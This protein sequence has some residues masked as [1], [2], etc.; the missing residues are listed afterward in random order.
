MTSL[1]EKNQQ[2]D[3]SI[4]SSH[5]AITVGVAGRGISSIDYENELQVL[6]RGE[7]EL[8]KNITGISM[9]KQIFLD[10]VHGDRVLRLDNYPEKDFVTY[11]QAD[12]IV[13][14]L[15]GLCL[16]IRTADCVPVFAFDPENHVMGASHSGWKGTMLKISSKMVELMC[17]EYGSKRENISIFIL[18][19]IGPNSYEV[20][21]DV[22]DH[23]NGFTKLITQKI[24]LNLWKHIEISLLETGIKKENIFNPGICTVISNSEFFSHRKG[25]KGRNLN[26]GYI[27]T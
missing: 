2:G 11:D 27:Q 26:Y 15:S 8:L 13:T 4:N 18:P 10:Q 3:Y 23:F 7:K 21:N 1:F 20:K 14:G 17:D 22:A 24:F 5:Q 25:D 16:V 12:G 19:S 9:E 6:R